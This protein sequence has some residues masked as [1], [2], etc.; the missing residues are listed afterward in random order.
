M[1]W[2]DGCGPGSNFGD[3]D[4]NEMDWSTDV[5]D[6]GVASMTGILPNLA[7]VMGPSGCEKYRDIPDGISG[8]PFTEGDDKPASIL[9]LDGRLYL[10][11]YSP[12]QHIAEGYIAYSE[13]GGATWTMAT[14]QAWHEEASASPRSYFRCLMLIN[15]GKN[16]EYN[17]DGYVY[18]LGIG[19]AGTG[20]TSAEVSC[21]WLEHPGNPSTTIP[22]SPISPGCTT[23]SRS[24]RPTSMMRLPYRDSSPPRPDRPY[25]IPDQSI[26]VPDDPGSF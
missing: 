10:A 12:Q 23:G 5:T 15:M 3:P 20:M 21:T 22:D 16:Y 2:G 4:C 18:G 9:A 14:G 24:G 13:D 8:F 26:P 6:A 17:A 1:T 19:W 25:F 7:C 11:G